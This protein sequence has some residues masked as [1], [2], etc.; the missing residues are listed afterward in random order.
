MR[1]CVSEK[2]AS[3]LGIEAVLDGG[4]VGQLLP[5]VVGALHAS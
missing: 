2:I 4:M 3:Q 5:L 1:L